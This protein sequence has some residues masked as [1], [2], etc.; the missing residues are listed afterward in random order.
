MWAPDPTTR[1]SSALGDGDT[2]SQCYENAASHPPQSSDPPRIAGE[3]GVDE[4]NSVSQSGEEDEI[5]QRE[6]QAEDGQLEPDSA[7]G[8][9]Y[10]LGEKGDEE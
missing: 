7:A 5:R 9:V 4:A 6:Q 8:R 2:E 10:E 1:H 3:P